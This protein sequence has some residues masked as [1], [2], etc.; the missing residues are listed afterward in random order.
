VSTRKP[1][2][3]LAAATAAVAVAIP[4]A[5]A[6]AAPTRQIAVPPAFGAGSLYCDVLH[7]ELMVAG[8]TGNVVMENYLGE[9]FIYSGCGGA[10]I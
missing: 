9:V 8:D 1:L 4:T 2:A 6:S 10:V 5:S 3:V 7:S